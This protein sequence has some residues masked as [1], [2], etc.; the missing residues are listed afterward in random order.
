MAQQS[1]INDRMTISVE[2]DF[3]V[4]L[5]GMRINKWWKIHKWLPIAIAMR[6][7]IT[8]LVDDPDSGLLGGQYQ[9]VGNPI[10]YV[11]YWR[12][13]EALLAY[14]HSSEKRH[15]KAWRGFYK[16]I[17]TS[18]DVG[19]WHEAYRI[20][21]GQYESVY[22]NMPPFGLGQIGP[23]LPARGQRETSRGRM[24]SVRAKDSEHDKTPA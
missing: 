15:Q 1:V 20:A 14:S 6:R 8:E 21:P 5:I 4:L 16:K 7:M 19:I 18:G 2:E 9:T 3:V 11:Q 23:L 12:S 13:Y 17:G 22:I 24:D 10:C